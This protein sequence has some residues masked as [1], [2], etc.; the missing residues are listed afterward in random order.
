M[1]ITRFL[2]SAVL[3]LPL[4][5]PVFGQGDLGAVAG[6]VIDPSGSPVGAADITITESA[7]NVASKIK[8]SQAGYY[9]ISV[10]AGNYVVQAEKDGFKLSKS[11][12]ITVGV[13]QVVSVDLKLEI[14]SNSET[15]TVTT[16]APLLSR[17]TSDIG[18]TIS[19]EEMASLP[20]EVDDGGRDLQTFVFKSLPGTTGNS[21]QGSINGGLQ[22]SHDILIDGISIAR[23]DMA[24][25]SLAEMQPPFDSVNE[26]KVQSG[27]YS[28]ESGSSGGSV[29]NFG[30][31]SG[32]NELHGSAFEYLKNNAF[33]ANG[34]SVNALPAGN[35]AKHK[36][37]L[38]DNN[39]G[40]SL[41]GPVFI[42]HLYNGK[43]KTFFYFNYEGDRF[44]GG[45]PSARLSLPTAG[46]LAGDFSS[47]LGDSVG[48][49][50]LGRDVFANEIFDP[51]TDRVVA[52]GA[53]D[54]VSGLTNTSGSSA[55]IRDP[56]SYNG[57]LNV[58]NPAKFSEVSGNML[59]LFPVP[60]LPGSINNTVRYR[61][62]VR[63]GA[64]A[65]S[66]KMD[67]AISD[68]NKISGFFNFN[69]R[70]RLFS[71]D[72]YFLPIPGF[73]LNPL[74]IQNVA[75]TIVRL[76]D[77]VTIGSSMVNHLAFGFNRFTNHNGLTPPGFKPSDFGLE[78][79]ADLQFPRLSFSTST[80]QPFIKRLGNG[81]PS[82]TASNSYIVTDTLSWVRGKHNF[83][84][85]GEMRRYQY[86]NA[87]Q[88]NESGNF[89]FGSIQ[90]SLPG[91]GD[92]TGHPFASFILG[93]VG[94]G[95]YSVFPI[96]PA[97][98]Q[99]MLAF[100][101]QDDWKI[102]PR[103]TLNLGLRWDIPLPR[104]ETK[105]RISVMDPTVPNPGADG[106][107]GA[108]VFFGDCDGC[109]GRRSP[110]DHYFREFAPRIGFAYSLTS[111]MVLR[112]GYGIT[113]SPP[114]ENN[115]GQQNFSGFAADP[116]VAF[117]ATP[118]TA[119]GTLDP[120]FYW[121][122]LTG[123][124]LPA[125]AVLGVPQFTG[126]IPDVSPTVRN[127]NSI[128]FLLRNSLAQPYQQ[129]WSFGFQYQLPK[130]ILFEANYVG[131]KG[132]RLLNSTYGL[133][134]NQAPSRYMALGDILGDDLATDL[135]DPTTAAILAANGIT[136]L[137]FSTFE[138]GSD[139]TVGQAVR[140]FPQY[141]AVTNNSL[142]NGDSTYNALQ[143]TVRKHS[144][145]GLDFIGS[146][147]FSK[148]LSNTDTALYYPGY[149]G[150]QDFYNQKAEK[151]VASFHVP[152]VVKLAWIYELPF[153]PG[154]R[155]L[156]STGVVGKVVG[157]WKVTAIQQY[158]AGNALAVYS[159]G[160][161]S[162]VGN[163]ASVRPDVVS[164]ISQRVSF[165]GSVDTE[166]GTPYLNPAAF[167]DVPA[168]PDNGFALRYGNAPR[169]LPNVRG[170]AQYSED[171][172]VM[173]ETQLSERFKLNF[174]MDAF[175]VFNRTG[176]GDPDT[177]TDSGQFG[178]IFSTRSDPRNIQ[179]SLRLSF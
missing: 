173:K 145:H 73:P 121:S 119:G 83:S 12:K 143:V 122:G 106:L 168:S 144:A 149:Y 62:Q 116:A 20:V 164:G 130:D 70:G 78:G 152:H 139:T 142:N 47:L 40:V 31:K 84:F 132:T 98:R 137:P 71:G 52:D 88:F 23:Y 50:A 105:N 32:T 2:C 107:L 112:G 38:K 99:G 53:V 179:F 92:S 45:S 165:S 68:K 140:P 61:G 46:M 100:F 111:K 95:S 86:N 151:S 17:E 97:Y 174:R 69:A 66:V 67:H 131:S 96:F 59:P 171:F 21:F 129:S 43:N 63:L 80:D 117:N 85:G 126:V 128:D 4:V 44:R 41:G 108:A 141:T 11:D 134:A 175:N 136:H 161:V 14:G 124:S 177:D 57:Q 54:P 26:F 101:G 160:I 147:A 15:V 7:T 33:N 87:P 162:A 148:T 19:R 34:F 93:G 64:N 9:R 81:G 18:G 157:G 102:S 166:N 22:F 49:D 115:F 104:T 65:Y 138:D 58:I 170:P 77:T 120:R 60:S 94:G 176:A 118:S 27:N 154:S 156:N 48:T 76:S 163:F 135:A 72:P 3:L 24:G 133:L 30:I 5:R 29:V 127:G 6:T 75:G 146:Y 8:T 114:I 51:T 123:A 158:R 155:W 113:Y 37:N 159:S 90:T 39:F 10:P 110:Q 56:F 91:F 169:F 35:I 74:K 103:L 79:V 167:A 109:V 36:A 82:A 89:S 153:G 16:E 28:A 1:R 178:L 172:G 55:V 13:A 25:G 150:V 125:G 42:P